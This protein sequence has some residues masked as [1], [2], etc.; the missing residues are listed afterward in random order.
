MENPRDI[1][2]GLVNPL[3]QHNV[4]STQESRLRRKSAAQPTAAQS[5]PAVR[6]AFGCRAVGKRPMRIVHAQI[7]ADIRSQL[8]KKA[9]T[10]LPLALVVFSKRLTNAHQKRY[11]KVGQFA[12]VSRPDQNRRPCIIVSHLRRTRLRS[13]ARFRSIRAICHGL[14][15]RWLVVA[16]ARILRGNL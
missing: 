4:V 6:I 11:P 12:S 5:E 7:A 13:A 10:A 15:L 2:I 3:S 14:P 8:R 1:K 16:L 9:S